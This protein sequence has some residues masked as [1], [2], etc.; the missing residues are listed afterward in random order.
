MPHY[1]KL[2]ANN[3]DTVTEGFGKMRG[4]GDAGLR[5]RQRVICG[6]E[7]R[8]RS[9]GTVGKMRGAVRGAWL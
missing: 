9:A 6:P 5:G 8:G 4:C 3:S 7:V 2:T 1:V